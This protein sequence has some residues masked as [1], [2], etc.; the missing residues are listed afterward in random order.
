MFDRRLPICCIQW[1][2]K[3]SDLFS[4]QLQKKFEFQFSSSCKNQIWAIYDRSQEFLRIFGTPL[5][6]A[7]NIK[8]HKTILHTSRNKRCERKDFSCTW[9]NCHSS[10]TRATLLRAHMKIHTNSLLRCTF[11]PF[12]TYSPHVL[13]LHYRVHYKVGLR[14]YKKGTFDFSQ[15]LVKTPSGDFKQVSEEF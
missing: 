5:Y 4:P 9:K 3:N 2:T 10:F 6:S 12:R 7:M 13:M 14:P 11:C 8:R 1:G 15:N